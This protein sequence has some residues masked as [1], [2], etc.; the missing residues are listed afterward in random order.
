MVD[1]SDAGPDAKLAPEN[2]SLLAPPD[3]GSLFD[4]AA[5][6]FTPATTTAA[7]TPTA[8]MPL[9]IVSE[10]QH[11]RMD[12]AIF[13][14][15]AG[16][17]LAS[18]LPF[19][20]LW[21]G[22]I[23]VMLAA[24]SRISL[25]RFA[26]HV[27][28]SAKME[29][30]REQASEHGESALWFNHVA[31]TVLTR[32]RRQ[33]AKVVHEHLEDLLE[34]THFPGLESIKIGKIDL[35]E[36]GLQIVRVR[37]LGGGPR[38]TELSVEAHIAYNE[39][40]SFVE[41]QLNMGR[42]YFGLGMSAT[43]KLCAINLQAQIRCTV[44]FA[45]DG[46]SNVLSAAHAAILAPPTIEF[47]LVPM[48]TVDVCKTFPSLHSWLQKMVS[49]AICNTMLYPGCLELFSNDATPTITGTPVRG[50]LLLTAENAT[51]LS[52]GSIF[53][54]TMEMSGQTTSTKLSAGP[55]PFWQEQ[56]ALLVR[57]LDSEKVMVRLLKHRPIR[58][59]L[60]KRRTFD[61]AELVASGTEGRLA[62]DMA[63]DTALNVKFDYQ[64]LD[65]LPADL[66]LAE[67]TVSDAR[68]PL[69]GPSESD[70]IVSRSSSEVSL[71]EASAGVIFLR[72]N[73]TSLAVSGQGLR[74]SVVQGA[75]VLFICALS[76]RGKDFAPPL[77]RS[78]TEVFVPNILNHP[79]LELR[80]QRHEG[81]STAT[82]GVIKLRFSSLAT[83]PRLEGWVPFDSVRSL[84]E[85]DGLSEQ[86]KD[87]AHVTLFFRPIRA[88]TNLRTED[89]LNSSN[90]RMTMS[91]GFSSPCGLMPTMRAGTL[92]MQIHEARNLPSRHGSVLGGTCNPF[93]IVQLNGDRVF[94]SD[95]LNKTTHPV[96]TDTCFEAPVCDLA[97]ECI[98]ILCMDKDLASEDMLGELILMLDGVTFLDA[99]QWFKLS[100]S[101][102]STSSLELCMTLKFKPMATTNPIVTANNA[103]VSPSTSSSSVPAS[104]G[105][106]GAAGAAG[107][108][109]S[110]C[111]SASESTADS[112]LS[113]S[114]NAVSTSTLVPAIGI[115]RVCAERATAPG[116]ASSS[117]SP[118]PSA[119]PRL[120]LADSDAGTQ[121]HYA[122]HQFVFPVQL[123]EVGQPLYT[124]HG[125]LHKACPI[126]SGSAIVK[127]RVVLGAKAATILK[128]EA[129][130]EISSQSVALID[131]RFQASQ[132][133]LHDSIEIELRHHHG[134]FKSTMGSNRISLRQFFSLKD[135]DTVDQPLCVRREVE[136]QRRDKSV[137]ALL[138]VS[139]TMT[140]TPITS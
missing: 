66:L 126:P 69:F 95:V 35:G 59:A 103:A 97:R 22:V 2:A 4:R 3:R 109:Q 62:F 123:R 138:V 11:L 101:Q 134:L 56:H 28:F 68:M 135:G 89:P 132:A 105:A 100:G 38:D 49:E 130:V 121:P 60:I 52:K 136:L 31:H 51:G 93:V 12:F 34:E 15:C 45:D 25:R 17:W 86:K 32:Y 84:H 78:W 94:R 85:A 41:L 106:A 87:K 92:F 102:G 73:R 30:L 79:P 39:P 91:M 33:I 64:P 5:S 6:I 65:A 107:P 83:S 24:W 14:A 129:P 54:V 104:A 44:L 108:T 77:G 82:I 124:L 74:V 23:F 57:S 67:R 115:V 127:L 137:A 90:R 80:L 63:A 99:P 120:S 116:E 18:F 13:A 98:H 7:P 140:L 40:S 119:R 114:D 26:H 117:T 71:H 110:L 61:M 37:T 53:G 9:W 55:A 48:G 36:T 29:T 47:G 8:S 111:V 88:S 75:R 131:A 27:A 81:L 125:Q 96:W 42:Q 43:V 128:V 58:K 19:S 72:L 21:A 1:K 70:S 122:D 112:G 16:L 113:V 133:Q 46:H 76:S 118:V 50:V 139:L 20:I 10:L